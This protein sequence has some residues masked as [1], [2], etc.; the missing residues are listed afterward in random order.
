[1]DDKKYWFRSSRNAARELRHAML[2]FRLRSWV[3]FHRSS[4]S[5]RKCRQL[6]AWTLWHHQ[7]I[8]GLAPDAIKMEDTAFFTNLARDAGRT[9]HIEGLTGLWKKLKAAL[10]KH[11][12]K[13]K[14]VAVDLH[15]ELLAHFEQFEGGTTMDPQLGP[16]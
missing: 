7:W 8:S 1:M 12:N 2:R 16:C 10:P 3:G 14:N 11:R 4:Y 15:P 5:I 6:L 9:A 13:R